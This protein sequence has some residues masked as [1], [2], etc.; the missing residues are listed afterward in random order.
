MRRREFIKVIAGSVSAWPFAARGQQI[1]QIRRIGVLL[2]WAADDQQAQANDA[3]F[4]QGM[5]ALGWVVGRNLQI[6]YRRAEGRLNRLPDLAAELVASRVDVIVA[7]TALAVLAASRAT[8]TIPIVQAGGGDPVISSHVAESLARPGN[9]TGL[10][11]QSE[12]LS[13]KLLELLLKIVPI[14]SRI[15][16]LYVP[17][18]PVTKPQLSQI[19]NSARALQV[20][21][22][23]VAAPQPD[24]PDSAL[25]ALAPANA[26]GMV[27][28]SATQ[29]TVQLRRIVAFAARLRLPAIYPYRYYVDAGGLMSYGVNRV[30]SSRQAARFV[31]RILKGARPADLPIEQPT[32]FEL[33]INLKTAK[34][35]GLTI[36]Q[37]LLVAADEVIE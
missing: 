22:D 4:L 28:L 36:P 6:D 25:D 37:S 26:A 13:S 33:I 24:A 7:V 14:A 10:T 19:Q 31:D 32:K 3:A 2:P 5:E 27:V 35:L 29:L 34:T 21:L 12:D 9:V 11:N 18:A 23:L 30:D 17:D 16:V 1:E 8:T 15:A 20:T